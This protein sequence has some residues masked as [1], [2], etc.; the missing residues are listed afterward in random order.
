MRRGWCEICDGVGVRCNG[1]RCN[2]RLT[3]GQRPASY[4]PRATPWVHHH[5]FLLQAEGLRHIVRRMPQSLSQV[6]LHIVFS[7]KDRRPFLDPSIRPRMHA[8][9]ATVCR[10]C[11]CEAYRVGGV[12]DHVHIAARMGRTISQADLL[13]KIKKT[14]S[15]WI[16]TQGKQF[17]SF[18]WQSGYGS[19]SIGQSQLDDLIRYVNNQET[20]HRT[21]TFQEEYRE[22]LLKY[23]VEFD[24]RYVWD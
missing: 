12:A 5:K 6:I 22:L 9:L 17:Q 7:T 8:Y 20:H 2:R 13:E 3:S 18:F 21:K 14:S 11:G 4:Q 10:D 23:N 1:L 16:K 15:A 19:F 24:E